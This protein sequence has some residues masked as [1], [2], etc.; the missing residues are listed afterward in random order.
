MKHDVTLDAIQQGSDKRGRCKFLTKL[1][2]KRIGDAAMEFKNNEASLDF[3]ALLDLAR[4][5]VEE[6]L[7]ADRL[8]S[9]GWR[10][11]L[12]INVST[13]YFNKHEKSNNLPLF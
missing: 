3:N 5:F 9:I 8:K 12:T 10:E 7:L 4:H 11:D 1:E 13:F 2:E 6:W